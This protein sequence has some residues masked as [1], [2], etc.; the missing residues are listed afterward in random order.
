VRHGT[1]FLAVVRR[2]KSEISVWDPYIYGIRGAGDNLGKYAEVRKP[3]ARKVTTPSR[4]IE[5]RNIPNGNYLTFELE[6]S[7]KPSMTA[8]PTAGEGQLLLGTLRAYLGNVIV[9][10]RAEWVAK[11]VP[12]FFPLKSEFVE[13]VPHDG[14]CYF[15]WAYL[16]SKAF[17]EQISLGHGG[18][19]P[20]LHPTDVMRTPVEVP[21]L[22]KRMAIHERL[23]HLA[24]E[25]WRLYEENTATLNAHGM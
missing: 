25:E 18:T 3:A 4:P 14:L 10:P 21:S 9:T 24:E 11:S 15:W 20:R 12:L 5:Y 17:R 6:F 8:M 16:R 22:E 19:R 13:I 23:Q 7:A 2:N 1:Y